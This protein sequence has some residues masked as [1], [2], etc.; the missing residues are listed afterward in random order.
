MRVLFVSSPGIGHLFPLI[1]LA[2]GFRTAGHDVLIAVAEHADRAAAA[3]LEV[4]DVAPD[5]SA[6][7]VF[8]QVA[9]DNPRFAE[10]VAT[11]PAID[12][13]E[14]GVQIA[15]VNRP[16]VD[17]T[18]A[19]TDDFRPDLV[20]YEQGA[21]VGLLAADRA[22]VPAV[23]RNQSAWR[24]RG[25]HRS[26]ASFLTDLMGKH[27]VSLP[28]PVAT[29]E[30]FPPSLLL[31]AEP[32]GWFMRW[33]PYGGGAV[34]GDRLPP[35]PARPEVAITMGTIELQA[36]GIGAV[37]PII[38]AAGE[39]DADF[40]L[41]LGDL[42]ISPLGTLPRNVRSVGWTPLHTLL[43]TCTAVVHHGGGGTVMTAIDAGIPQLL[44][45]DPRDQFQHTAREAVS[46]RGIGL[47]STSDKVDADLLRRLVGDESLR[48]AAREVRE[49]MVALPTPAETVRRI[50]ERIS[51]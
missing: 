5:F 7:K 14:W 32:E 30:S 16:L 42:D 1:Q 34:L 18:I 2:W 24:T 46:R 8:E 44:A 12:L 28:E 38:A 11:R 51:G 49:E 29:I 41:A 31:E 27:Q 9:K 35:V 20:V 50:V 36:F 37:E 33:V 19:L 6:V 23:Q 15:A 25:M 4:V 47:V 10:T 17:G 22:G 43:R 48:T 13:E 40:V 45:P 39:V 26:I 21:T 3:G